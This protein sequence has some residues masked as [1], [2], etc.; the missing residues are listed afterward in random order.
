MFARTEQSSQR[1][2]QPRRAYDTLFATLL[3]SVRSPQHPD[4]NLAAVIPCACWTPH[5]ALP[6]RLGACSP[7]QD[8]GPGGL[9]R[10]HLFIGRINEFSIAHRR[11]WRCTSRCADP[12]RRGDLLA[13][14]LASVA[15][16]LLML[17]TTS[18]SSAMPKATCREGYPW[19]S[20]DRLA[21]A[22]VEF[23]RPF[24]NRIR[25]VSAHVQPSR[26]PPISKSFVHL[27]TCRWAFTMHPLIQENG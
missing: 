26:R 23:C 27:L 6:Q 17:A 10:S 3:V 12:S 9:L 8:R 15:Q 21:N 25:G 5:R 18:P 19:R 20:I 7:G 14:K 4:L 22:D 16:P 11:L 24:P 2:V 1:Q 13:G